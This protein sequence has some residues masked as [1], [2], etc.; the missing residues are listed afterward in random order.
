MAKSIDNHIDE[1]EKNPKKK[2]WRGIFFVVGI[3]VVIGVASY[4]FG[5]V[6]NLD[7]AG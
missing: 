1:F 2:I 4:L 3:V 7:G 5:W 6:G